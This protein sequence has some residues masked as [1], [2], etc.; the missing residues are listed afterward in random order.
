MGLTFSF[1][2]VGILTSLFSSAFD[3]NTV[4]QI[5][6]IILIATGI[7]F[8]APK[9]KD[10]ITHKLS[11]IGNKGHNLQSKIKSNDIA[12]Q[13][14]MGSVLGM[15]WGPCSGP[16][17][18]FA[19][20]IASQADQAFHATIIFFFFGLGAGLGL[21]S[22]GA[23]LKKFSSLT[24]K[25]LKHTIVINRIT[26][27]FSILI[28]SLIVTGSLGTLEEVILKVMPAWIINLSVSL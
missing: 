25:L 27:L 12:S 20:G 18:A 16:T 15:I 7:V 21:I 22:L 3:V 11:F 10:A 17:L 14:L 28:G 13:F 8:L 23:L 19:F 1:T 26:G 4:Q 6:A 24:A 2:L 9:L 5:G